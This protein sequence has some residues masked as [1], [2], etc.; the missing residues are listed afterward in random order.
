M[1]VANFQLLIVNCKLSIKKNA[2]HINQI[3]VV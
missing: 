2:S 1:Q 3:S